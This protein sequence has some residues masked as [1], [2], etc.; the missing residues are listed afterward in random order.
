M[1]SP[2]PVITQQQVTGLL[3]AR[4]HDSHKGIFGT[5]GVIGGATGMTG[6]ALLAAR[7][8]LK[9][10]AGCVHVV[11]LADDAP[12][13]D[14]VQPELMIHDASAAQPLP[15]CTVLAIGCGMGRGMSAQKRLY[16]ALH[17]E[18]ALVLDADALN[19]L[20]LRPDLHTVLRARNSATVLTPHPGEAARL[21]NCSS[22]E[23]QADRAASVQKLKLMFGCALV[24]KGADSLCITRDGQ[25]FVNT[26]G[27]PGMSTPGMGDV[28]S[29]MIAAF[30]AQGLSADD[31]LLLAVHLHGAAGDEL[32]KQTAI[33]MTATEVTDQARRLLNIWTSQS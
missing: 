7:A 8:A 19:I 20:A 2:I 9:L 22:A 28:L 1:S 33:G 25:M 3:N 10:G 11:L 12:V 14:F 17:G 32:A 30:I 23:V 6:A 16:D 15:T 18:A 27:N 4:P 26:T 21:L 5:V 13:V 29:G 31:A 24:L